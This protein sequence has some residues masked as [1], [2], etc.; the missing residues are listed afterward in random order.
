MC[1]HKYIGERSSGTAGGAAPLLASPASLKVDATLNK[2]RS[3]CSRC[4]V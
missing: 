4:F 2:D 3:D 1:Y